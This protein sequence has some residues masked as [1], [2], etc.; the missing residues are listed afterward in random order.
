MQKPFTQWLTEQLKP[1][2]E[3]DLAKGELL[4]RAGQSVS[5]LYLVLNG[6]IHLVRPL[7]HGSTLTI[8][9]ALANSILA[10][11]SMF[12]PHYH[13]DAV[14]QCNSRLLCYNRQKVQQQLRSQP[15][16][17][18]SL[19]VQ[20]SAE[21]L[22]LRT[23]LELANIQSADERLLTWIKLQLP[24]QTDTLTID[25]SFKSIASELGLAHETLY[26]SLKRLEEL[27][28][29]QRQPDTIVLLPEY[30]KQ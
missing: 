17:S 24:P 20:L 9:R 18:E 22:S 11:A 21:I 1:D 27:R 30:S 8:H 3:R 6:E 4:F 10:E 23:K 14:A 29:I 26:R 12:A 16:F 5:K 25:R 19:S 7:S 15:G 13:C 28:L 2:E